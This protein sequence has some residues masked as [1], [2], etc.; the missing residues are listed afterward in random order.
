MKISSMRY[1]T[2]EGLKNV[3][4]NRLMTL[5]SVG[6]LVACMVLIGLSLLLSMNITKIMGN[7]EKQNVVMVFFDDYNAA[8]YDEEGRK[9][10]EGAELDK[11]GI[12]D[13][14][15]TVHNEEEAKA[16]CYE[17][18]GIDNVASAT[19]VSKEESLEIAKKNISKKNESAMKALEGENN[20]FSL[21]AR[22]TMEKLEDFDE[23]I[24]AIKKING[25][26][27]IRAQDD[28]AD[29]ITSIKKGLSIAGIAIISILLI[30]SLIIVSNTIRVTMYN[31]KLEISIMK[32]VGATDGFIRI[33]FIIE[34]VAIGLISAVIS[35]GILYCCYR[36]AVEAILSGIGINDV[37]FIS[38]SSKALLLFGI[39]AG[40]GI[41][42]GAFGSIIMISKYLKRE[43]SEFSAI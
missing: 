22:V 4:V 34:G 33:P 18:A 2:K 13:Q 9:A 31:R 16:I 14:M 5:S 36:V 21:G 25:V 7:L 6:V 24:A 20:P 11:N 29:K 35:E 12:C 41:I 15:F 43:G 1:L 30:I 3:W 32:A 8:L 40:I 39:F 19:F 27:N 42:A 38:F 26:D 37:D 23:T 28:L 10:P 17:I